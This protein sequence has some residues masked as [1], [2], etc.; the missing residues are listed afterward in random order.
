MAVHIHIST[1]FPEIPGVEGM[2]MGGSRGLVTISSLGVRVKRLQSSPGLHSQRHTCEGVLQGTSGK[3]PAHSSGTECY[4]TGNQ[5]GSQ[6]SPW[7]HSSVGSSANRSETKIG[8]LH[9]SGDSGSPQTEP[10][11]CEKSHSPLVPAGGGQ[12]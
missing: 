7:I 12:R 11:H 8:H 10:R 2:C 4:W 6:G 3:V 1:H 9:D 5:A